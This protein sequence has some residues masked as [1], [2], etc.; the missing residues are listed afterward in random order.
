M[1]HT[2]WG[3][4]CLLREAPIDHKGVRNNFSKRKKQGGLKTNEKIIESASIT[5]S[6]AADGAVAAANRSIV[7][8]SLCGEF[9]FNRP[10]R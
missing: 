4:D 1:R 5:G 3:D 9:N 6:G 10:V 8:D 2:L 7:C